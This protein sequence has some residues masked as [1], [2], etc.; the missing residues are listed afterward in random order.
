MRVTSIKGRAYI[1]GGGFLVVSLFRRQE[2][3]RRHNERSR[4][5]KVRCNQGKATHKGSQITARKVVFWN[6]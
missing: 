6:T 5:W 4:T 1:K 2:Q 3:Q